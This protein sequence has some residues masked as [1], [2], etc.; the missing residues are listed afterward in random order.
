M[1]IQAKINERNFVDVDKE[2]N[3]FFDD[4]H[5]LGGI[6]LPQCLHALKMDYRKS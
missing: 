2:Q 5:G 4:I 3:L 1:R 6:F